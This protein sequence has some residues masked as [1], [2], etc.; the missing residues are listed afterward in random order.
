MSG[1]DNFHPDDSVV[2]VQEADGTQHVRKKRH[3]NT[4]KPVVT[5]VIIGAN[6][7]MF[8]L[9]MLKSG[10][11][12]FSGVSTGVLIELGAK[13]NWLIAEGEIWRLLTCTFLHAGFTHIL[14]NMWGLW[15]WGRYAEVLYGKVRYG[16]IYIFSG[17]MGSILSFWLS[18]AVSIGASGAL[19]GVLGA[20]CYIGISDRQMFRRLLGP[21][22]FIIIGINLFYGFTSGG[23][24]NFGHL[25]G[26]IGGFVAAAAVGLYKE[27]WLSMKRVLAAAV[28]AVLLFGSFALG[29]NANRDD[30]RYLTYRV[31]EAQKQKD[32]Q[33]MVELGRDALTRNG[34]NVDAYKA[35]AYGAT[36]LHDYDTAVAAAKS[37][38]ALKEEGDAYYVMAVC[39][40]NS[41]SFEDAAVALEKGLV[42][43]PRDGDM[44]ELYEKVQQMLQKGGGTRA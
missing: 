41:G 30:D 28:A 22:L 43:S 14:F 44:L 3:W 8:L 27:R 16:I 10:F 20:L 42:L 26:L 1:Y 18:P 38:I 21:Q 33:Q 25:G 34:D 13:A 2:V 5:Q 19:F 11:T 6:L 17:L 37:W 15:I 23:V 40:Y 7:V 31:A 9:E 4:G 36:N 24:D 39:Y 29:M 12:L 32:Y 35:I